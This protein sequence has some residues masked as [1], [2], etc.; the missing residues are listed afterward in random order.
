MP[1][2][3][4]DEQRAYQRAWVNRR[5]MEGIRALGGACARCGTE[6]GPFD[7]DHKDRYTKT[8]T[9]A[10]RCWSWRKE[11]RG[12]ELAK[13]Q[14]LCEPCHKI[15]TREHRDYSPRKQAKLIT[16]LS[17]VFDG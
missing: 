4:R 3:N 12:E 13:C 2:A 9:T 16:D 10:H 6:E 14:L 1:Y 7:L 17:Q 15:K 11:R 8:F 5:R